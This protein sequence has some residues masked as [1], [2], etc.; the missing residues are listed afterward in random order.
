MLLVTL[1]LVFGTV[2]PA[3]AAVSSSHTPTDDVAGV[4]YAVAQVGNRTII[5][6]DFT[7]VGGAP[8]QNIAAL[9]P[10]GSVDPGFNP[11]ANGVVKALDATWDGSRLFVGGEFSAVNGVG[12]S[13]LAALDAT[14]G[15]V[16]GDWQ[17]DTNGTVHAVEVW[18]DRVYAA[19]D[20]TKI[21]G[22]NRRRLAAV[23][24]NSSQVNLTF[25]PQP[26]WTVKDIIVSPD[27]SRVYA[28]GGF[29]FFNGDVPRNGLAEVLTS[30]G[31][32]TSFNPS[33]GGVGLAVGLT[34][35]GSRL[36]FSTTNNRL[37]AY[38]PA[39]SNAPVY[40]I[41]TGGDTQ[42]I[43]ASA[44]EVYFG[45]H[46]RNVSTFK[47]KRN[48][49][50]SIRVAD[51]QLTSWDPRLSGNLGPWAIE[52]TADSVIVGGDFSRVNNKRQSGVAFFH[53]TP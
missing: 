43:A 35:D 10:N 24:I 29:N 52:L 4:V 23:D 8:R 16:V 20:F 26:S 51:G 31:E 17:A 38:D 48:L 12:R 7:A 40:T 2:G 19:G 45:G 14:T 18:A 30:T 3:S 49:L 37:Y 5:G 22:Q 28:G 34:P 9:L 41:Q 44:T 46:F 50:A 13:G 53:G 15:T 11:G 32:L 36:Y 25:N 47:A 39:S 6:G 33:V 21:K 1:G 27:G 42:A